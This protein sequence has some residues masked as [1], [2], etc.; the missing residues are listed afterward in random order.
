[1]LDII[2]KICNGISAGVMIIIGC[3]IF[4]ACDNKYVGA[5][6]FAVALLTICFKGYSLFTGKVGYLPEKHGKEE[7]S[8]LLLGLLGNSIATIFLGFAIKYAVPNLSDKAELIC[9][10][11]LADQNTLQTFIRAIFCGILMY[12]AVSVYRDNKTTLGILFAIPVF[13]LSGFEHSIADI[14]YF[15]I[16]GI[17]SWEAFG[18]LWVVIA[19]N[20]VGSWILPLLSFGYKKSPK[21]TEEENK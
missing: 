11:K 19:G 14:G 2:K 20:A 6:L 5:V 16:S 3:S 13:I 10:A 1:M 12:V 7:I 17:V 15:A 18:F 8:V 9:S 21:K 4:L